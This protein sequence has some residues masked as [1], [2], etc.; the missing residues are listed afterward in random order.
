MVAGL[1]VKLATTGTAALTVTVTLHEELEPPPSAVTVYVVVCVGVT[2][3]VPILSTGPIPGW[4]LTEAA[5]TVVQANVADWP[6]LM[7]DGVAAPPNTSTCV[8]KPITAMVAVEVS[9]FTLLRAVSTYVVVVV[10]D[11]VSVPEV[12][13]LPMPEIF[14]V[15]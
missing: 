10:G 15:S 2:V 7:V 3:R 9:S 13:T 4:M 5:F 11:T 8:G 12:A 14:T 6:G 1:A